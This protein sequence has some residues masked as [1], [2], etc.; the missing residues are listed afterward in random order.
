M[1]PMFIGHY[2]V[3]FA[4]KKVAPRTSLGTLIFAAQFLDFLWPV[5]LLLGV[6]HA[7]IAP[8]I[9]KVSPLNFTDYPISHS[10]LMALIWSALVGGI[11]FAVRR[12]GRTAWVIGICVLSHW[13]LDF[14]TH[15]PD[16]PLWPGSGIRVG[17]G[18]W[19]SWSA[20]MFVEAIIFGG[21]IWL[22]LR[23][24]RAKDRIG[25]Y[26]LWALVGFLFIGWVSSLLAGPPPN[27]TSLAWGGLAMMF[28]VPWGWWADGRR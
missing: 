2:G 14:V 3:A 22:Y 6:E 18:L 19:N 10:L 12:A 7:E 17:L 27:M 16:L 15:R 28:T 26:V 4:A 11:W 5:L 24:T 8:G 9:T 13:V 20:A 1:E 21:G 23:S 25:R